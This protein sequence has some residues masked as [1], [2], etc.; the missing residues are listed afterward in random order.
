VERFKRTD[1]AEW[2]ALESDQTDFRNPDFTVQAM[3]TI[4]CDG[5]L[6]QRFND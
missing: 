6:L 5:V 2:L 4:L 3:R 1:D